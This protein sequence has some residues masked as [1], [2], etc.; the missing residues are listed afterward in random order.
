MKV[1]A[2]ATREGKW[3]AVEVP[4][5]PGVFT[6]ARRLEH[7]PAMVADAVAV[8]LDKDPGDVEVTEVRPALPKALEGDVVRARKLA[9]EATLIQYEASA[10]TRQ[11]VEELREAGLTVRDVAEILHV[12]PQRISQL[13]AAK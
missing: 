10:A 8:M 7:V 5:V 6:Q 11:A 3:W 12:S 1:T 13:V 2:I 9:A 4:E